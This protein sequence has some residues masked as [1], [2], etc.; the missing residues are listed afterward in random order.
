MS[1]EQKA[2][3]YGQLLSHHTRLHNQISEIKSQNIDLNQK[4]LLEIKNLE[5]QQLQI[6][7]K[8]NQLLSR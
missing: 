6:M 4:Q 1:E 5:N 7:R 8:I 2:Q 3:I